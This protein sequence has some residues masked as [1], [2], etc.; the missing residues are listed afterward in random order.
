MSIR[1]PRG[2]QVMQL[3]AHYIYLLMLLLLSYLKYPFY[4][5]SL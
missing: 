4:K 2:V 3:F 5:D 1:V